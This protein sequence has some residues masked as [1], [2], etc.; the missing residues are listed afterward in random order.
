MTAAQDDRVCARVTIRGQVQ[1]VFFR[2]STVEEAR[3]H[4]LSGWVRNRE[5]RSVEAC[6]IGPRPA[7]EAVLAWCHEGPPAAR[8]DQ[9]EVVWGKPD[10]ADDG[11]EVRY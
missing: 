2:A 3:R 5:D 11:F 10:G 1:G 4:G 7:V 8:V 6:L 9:V